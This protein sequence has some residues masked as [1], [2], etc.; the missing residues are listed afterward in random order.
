MLSFDAGTYQP[1]PEIHE[2]LKRA[3]SDWNAPENDE[4]GFLIF[5]EMISLNEGSRVFNLVMAQSGDLAKAE[6][7]SELATALVQAQANHYLATLQ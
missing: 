5:G 7:A 2:R 1:G 3:L 4:S 6:S